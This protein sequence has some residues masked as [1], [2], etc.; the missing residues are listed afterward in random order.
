MISPGTAHPAREFSIPRRLSIAVTLET[1]LAKENHQHVMKSLTTLLHEGAPSYNPGGFLGSPR[2]N[3]CNIH[4]FFYY[5]DFTLIIDCLCNI[6]VWQ[7]NIHSFIHDVTVTKSCFFFE[8]TVPRL[9]AHLTNKKNLSL[10]IKHNVALV[11]KNS[12]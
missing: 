9:Q 5:N 3:Y 1:N 10:Q 2:H 11:T 4:L 7:I 8:F 12:I 6:I